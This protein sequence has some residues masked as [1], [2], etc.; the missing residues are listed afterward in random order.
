MALNRLLWTGVAAVTLVACD[1]LPDFDLRDL[2]DGFDTSEAVANLPDR[3]APDGRG[4]IS[5]PNYQVVVAQQDDTI[6]SIA[7]RLN[8]DVAELASFNGIEPDIRLRRDEIVALPNRVSEPAG[9]PIQTLDITSIATTALDRAAGEQPTVTTLPSTSPAAPATPQAAPEPVQHK[10]QRGETIFQ[11]S[12]LY[13]VPVQNLTEWNGLGSDLTIREGQVL[14][15]PQAGARPPAQPASPAVTEPGAGTETPLPPS[16]ATPLPADDT[17]PAAEPT[18]A[19]ETPDLGTPAPDTS[20]SS[21]RLIRPVEGSVI[22]AY[23]PGRN[24]GIDIG[25]PAGTSVKAADS[26]SV[27]AVTTDTNGV[28]IVVIRHADNLLTVYTNLEDLSVAKNDSVSRGQ[29]IGA[30]KSGDPSFLHFE[31]RRG[32][33]ALDPDDFL[34]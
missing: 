18:P 7:T 5:Y 33:E 11:I 4:V 27:A 31:V 24:D 32:L 34:P 26:G 12:R 9:G 15:I 2:G 1:T 30:V 28:A 8:I 14:L 25:V 22:R 6:R 29:T 21:A 19:P 17:T 16:A 13:N 3:P 20:S 23:S 10:V